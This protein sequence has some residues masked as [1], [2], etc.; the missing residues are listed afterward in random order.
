[1]LF[2]ATVSRGVGLQG[3]GRRFVRNEMNG[4]LP[5]PADQEGVR[6]GV[7]FD[8]IIHPD[9]TTSDDRTEL[10]KLL[11]FEKPEIGLGLRFRE[12]S[13]RLPFV[14]KFLSRSI[15]AAQDNTILP[16]AEV[17]DD[18]QVS[19]TGGNSVEERE[20]K[21]RGNRQNMPCM[22]IRRSSS[23]MSRIR[24]HSVFQPWA[25]S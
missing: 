19:G 23:P 12:V 10:I 6:S 20:E 14:Q 3:D 1:M 5:E 24:G 13:L 4:P 25:P 21:V 22:V 9:S 18:L 7:G 8:W 11:R 2:P 17:A 16:T 15:I